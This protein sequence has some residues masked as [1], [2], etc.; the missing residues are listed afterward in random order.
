MFEPEIEITEG[1]DA[2]VPE[3]EETEGYGVL[4]PELEE[5]GQEIEV[6]EE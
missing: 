3:L 4:V 1:Y 6:I 2:L 5:L